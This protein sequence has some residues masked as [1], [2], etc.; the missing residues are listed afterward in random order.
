M[1]NYK[2]PPEKFTD[3]VK[4]GEAKA[5][6]IKSAGYDSVDELKELSEDEIAEIDGIGPAVAG[7]IVAQLDD[8]RDWPEPTQKEANLSDTDKDVARELLHL[9]RFPPGLK[10]RYADEQN[11]GTDIALLDKL[12]KAPEDSE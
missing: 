4:V 11:D 1:S 8:E 10:Q 6:K 2:Q 9:T 5:N 3:L 7:T 12:I